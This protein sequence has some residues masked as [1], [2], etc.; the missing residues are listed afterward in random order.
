MHSFSSFNISFVPRE[1]NQKTDS[2]AVAASLFNPDGFQNH[3][4]FQ[5]KIIFN[6][7][8][9]DNQDHLQVFEN[10]EEMDDFLIDTDEILNDQLSISKKSINFK[11]I[12]IRDDQVRMSKLKE[13]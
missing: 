11:S 7:S 6:P 10:D 9:P 13:E 12:F 8:I 2:L 1:R 4:I 5:V 3:N